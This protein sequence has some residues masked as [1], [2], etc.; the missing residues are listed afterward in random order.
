MVIFGF[1]GGYFFLLFLS[2]FVNFLLCFW[3]FLVLLDV[4]VK[5]GHV[6]KGHVRSGQVMLEKVK[7]VQAKSGHP[8]SG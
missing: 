3:V 5:S 4:V 6:R 2:V 7:S 8:M 1:F